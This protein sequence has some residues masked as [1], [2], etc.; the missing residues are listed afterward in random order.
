MPLYAP[1]SLIPVES[2]HQLLQLY[3]IPEA[4]S[5]ESGQVRHIRIYSFDLCQHRRRLLYSKNLKMAARVMLCLVL[6]RQLNFNTRIESTVNPMKLQ[7]LSY[8]DALSAESYSV[9][10]KGDTSNCTFRIRFFAHPRVVP[11]R[12]VVETISKNIGGKNTQGLVKFLWRTQSNYT[13][14]GNLWI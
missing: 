2:L 1:L 14:R 12:V 7:L 3:E 6:T 11:G 13:T 9:V 8:V 4:S 5:F 10:W